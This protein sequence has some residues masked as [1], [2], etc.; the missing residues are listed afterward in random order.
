MTVVLYTKNFYATACNA[1][2][3]G[4]K[5]SFWRIFWAFHKSY[6]ACKLIHNSSE[7]LKTTDNRIAIFGLIFRC[8][9]IS[10]ESVDRDIFNNF[11]AFE[12]ERFNWSKHKLLTIIPGCFGLCIM[13]VSLQ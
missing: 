11:A 5:C 3:Y 10:L 12:I 6:P 1:Y 7:V 2:G 4:C 8:P 9:L 13:F